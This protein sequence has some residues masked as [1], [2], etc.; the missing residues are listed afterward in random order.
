MGNATAMPAP[1]GSPHP[2]PPDL[3]AV[4]TS[5]A[6]PGPGVGL[7]LLLHRCDDLVLA[8]LRVD[9]G[10]TIGE[11]DNWRRSTPSGLQPKP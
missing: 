3:P 2:C 10:K 1:L 4:F 7:K 8:A 11:E 9:S 6:L 5:G